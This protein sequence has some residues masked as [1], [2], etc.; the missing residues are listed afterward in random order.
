MQQSSRKR[1]FSLYTDA[2]RSSVVYHWLFTS[3]G[4]RE[5]DTLCLNLDGAH[6]HGWQ[7]MG[8]AHYLG[9]NEAHHNFFDQCPMSYAL[10]L[11]LAQSDQDPAYALIYCYLRDWHQSHPQEEE[12]SVLLAKEHDPDY[13]TQQ[14]EASYWV[15][16]TLVNSSD[17]QQIDDQLRAL[18][19]LD[20]K[21]HAVKLGKHHYH[22]SDAA[23]KE[24]V[25]CLYDFQCQICQ[26]RVYR[27][28]WLATLPR[29]AQWHFLNADAHH[30]LP[31]YQE[32]P[33]SLDNLLCLCPTCHRKFHTEQLHLIRHNQNLGCEDVILGRQWQVTEKHPIIL[34]P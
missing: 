12:V 23:L 10:S 13:Q 28:G 19:T 2:E 4:F 25:K 33:D 32:G 5:L 14:V 8:I 34:H 18:A 22:V 1:E 30:I 7:S 16:H 9:L 21:K 27:P 26:T 31:L 15:L 6:S 3:N 17:E 20:P 11:L 29:S 24:A